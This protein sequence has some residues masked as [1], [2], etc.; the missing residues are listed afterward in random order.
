MPLILKSERCDYN[1]EPGRP[2]Q[3][4][5]KTKTKR[6]SGSGLDIPSFLFPSP[7]LPPQIRH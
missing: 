6:L 3:T 5:T 7:Q 2:I 4:Q 1:D